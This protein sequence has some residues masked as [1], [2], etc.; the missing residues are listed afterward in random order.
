MTIDNI[1]D[2]RRIGEEEQ[3]L[4]QQLRE[5]SSQIESTQKMM[6]SERKRLMARRDKQ[7]ENGLAMGEVPVT[8]DVIAGRIAELRIGLQAL[9]RKYSE[10]H[11]ALQREAV[12]AQAQGTLN[13]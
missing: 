12:A 7:Q 4:R 6:V 3:F 2:F 11:A 13:L 8:D 9:Q 1:G 5:L 10:Y